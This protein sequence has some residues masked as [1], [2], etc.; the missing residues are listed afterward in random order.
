MSF[1]FDGNTSG[2]GVGGNFV[3][4]RTSFLLPPGVY[5]FDFTTRADYHDANNVPVIGQVNATLRLDG[6]TQLVSFYMTGREAT[7]FNTFAAG[8]GSKVV[9]ITNNQSVTMNLFANFGFGTISTV[10]LHDCFLNI[11]QLQ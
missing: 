6:F 3:V 5:R 11:T 8:S 7:A 1:S 2:T 9:Q 10:G 4:P